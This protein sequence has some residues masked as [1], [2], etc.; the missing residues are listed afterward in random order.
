MSHLLYY[1]DQEAFLATGLS[2]KEIGEAINSDNPED[3]LK[4]KGE[5]Y[6]KRYL[7]WKK[8]K[9]LISSGKMKHPLVPI[10]S[11]FPCVGKTG[12]AKEIGAMFGLGDIMGGDAFRASLRVFVSK[13]E[14]PAF[15]SSI[16]KAWKFFGDETEENIIK[17]F[18]AQARI[19][20]DA[21]ERIVVDR[22]IRDGEHM[23]FEYLHFLPSQYKKEV[24]E[25]PSIIP[26]VLR[27]DSEKE[28]RRRIGLRDVTA[29]LKG[30]SDRLLKVL[31]KYRLMQEYQCKEAKEFGIPVVSTDNWEAGLDK[32]VDIIFDGID[33]LIDMH[34]KGKEVDEEKIIEEFVKEREKFNG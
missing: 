13:E 19:M 23:V 8:Y 18:K 20:N 14:N 26:I 1:P 27:I 30:A 31:D 25:H 32:I 7:T 22:G 6:L 28:H 9:E 12:M 10:I 16:Y 17:G 4:G 5:K 21:I 3:A 24:L 34:E 29:H 15:F 11:A 33:N 2:L